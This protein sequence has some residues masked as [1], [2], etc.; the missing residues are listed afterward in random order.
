MHRR[1]SAHYNITTYH[2]ACAHENRAK[3]N[4]FRTNIVQKRAEMIKFRAREKMTKG[5]AK[6]KTEYLWL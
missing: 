2:R 6:A 3:M 5:E 4:D 1:L